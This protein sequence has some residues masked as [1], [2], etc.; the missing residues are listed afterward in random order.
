MPSSACHPDATSLN[1]G[2]RLL[3]GGNR[4]RAVL[5]LLLNAKVLDGQSWVHGHVFER[6]LEVRDPCHV[7]DGAAEVVDELLADDLPVIPRRVEDLADRGCCRRLTVHKAERFRVLGRGDVLEPKHLPRLE[8]P[9]EIRRLNRGREMVSIMQPW[10]SG[11]NLASD[12]LEYRW[13]VSRGGAGVPVLLAGR[14][15]ALHRLV[16]VANS[17]VCLEARIRGRGVDRGQS[18]YGG[19]RSDRRVALSQVSAHTAEKLLL[20]AP[21]S[22]PVGHETGHDMY[23]RV[24]DPRA[25]PPPCH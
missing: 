16:M 23:R 25:S 3:E 21:G 8:G 6:L 20:A 24:A 1:E 12:R 5:H 22:V 10:K 17:C 7:G 11:A 4:L 18:G 19:L 2:E 14:C 9:A 15:A 13:N